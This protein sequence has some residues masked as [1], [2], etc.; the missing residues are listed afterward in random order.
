MDTSVDFTRTVV[1]T[2]PEG[3]ND[4]LRSFLNRSDWQVIECPALEIS[5]IDLGDHPFLPSPESYDLV[6]FVSIPAVESFGRQ[7]AQRGIASLWPKQTPI[8]CVGQATAQAIRNTFGN[9]VVVLQPV[10]ESTQDSENLWNVLKPSVD[11]LKRVLIVRGQDG[12]DWL[13]TRLTENGCQVDFHVAYCR[14]VATWSSASIAEFQACAKAR[15]YPIWILTS[16]HGIEATIG[17]LAHLGLLQ[18][19]VQCRFLLTHPRQEAVLRQEFAKHLGLNE[20]N[21]HLVKL[22]TNISSHAH[23]ELL[24]NLEHFRDNQSQA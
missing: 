8:G 10:G 11:A 2:R 1:L 16:A 24:S 13:A 18:W 3:R 17:Q 14:K 15:I 21:E 9:Q 5:S 4:E 12:R 6:I 22:N 20:S 23:E 7:L 19:A